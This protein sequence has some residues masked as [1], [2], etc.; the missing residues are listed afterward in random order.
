MTSKLI[1]KGDGIYTCSN[2]M[3][4]QPSLQEHCLWC[5]NLFYNYT[6]ILIKQFDEQI[7]GEIKDES[8]IC[9]RD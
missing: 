8:N 1:D 7:R 2:C 9:G 3:M 6:D 5:G 4:R